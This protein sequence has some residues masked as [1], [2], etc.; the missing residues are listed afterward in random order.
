MKKL[1]LIILL[2]AFAA[3]VVLAFSA[4]HGDLNNNS[5]W[6]EL[7]LERGADSFYGS[8]DADDWPYSAPNQPPLYLLMFASSAWFDQ[9]IEKASFFL[10]DRFEA[11]PS[12]FIWWWQDRGQYL[13]YKLWGILGDLGIAVLIFHYIGKR[14]GNNQAIIY[15]VFWLVN[16]VIWFNS[17]IWGQ[18]DS[19]VNFFGLAAVMNLLSGNLYLFVFLFTIGFLYKA[20]LAMFIP[21]LVYYLLKKRFSFPQLLISL[22]I[23]LGTIFVVSVWFHPEPDYP[24]WFTDLYR[25]RILSGEIADLT[26]NAFNFWWLINPQEVKD[27][28]LLVGVP[29]RNI[30][31][32]VSLTL[33]GIII[34]KIRNKHPQQYLLIAL[35]LSAFISF[36]FMTRMHE[37]YLY[38]F[39]PFSTLILAYVPETTVIYLAISIVHLL[40]L[41]YRFEALRFPVLDLAYNQRWFIPFLA[42]FTIVLCIVW[43]YFSL[44]YSGSKIPNNRTRSVL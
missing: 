6:G 11:F 38:P 40:N 34:W 41:Y 25:N 19:V 37:R 17:S 42:L 8:S 3:R 5:S 21:V 29:A 35:A 22:G 26:A 24:I 4:Y 28:L 10:N 36:L 14:K 32:L 43:G 33:I 18:T 27:T 1:L 2:V 44:K 13:S 15:T 9:G 31:Y 20:S 7:L 30:G 16:P 12:K 39:F 23:I